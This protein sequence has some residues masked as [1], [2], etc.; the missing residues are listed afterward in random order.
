M[1][2]IRIFCFLMGLFVI[3]G[4]IQLIVININN[5]KIRGINIIDIVVFIGVLIFFILGVG[6]CI[7][8]FV[9]NF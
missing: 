5:I 8:S 9:P 1:I 3:F 2:L 4:G 6:L 7:V